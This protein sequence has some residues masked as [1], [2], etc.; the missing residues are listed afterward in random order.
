MILLGSALLQSCAQGNLNFHSWHIGAKSKL[1][2]FLTVL[3][4]VKLKQ[5]LVATMIGKI[6]IKKKM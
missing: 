6:S 4:A 1:L 5:Q 2:H 3:H